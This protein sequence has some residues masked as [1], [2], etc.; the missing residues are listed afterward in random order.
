MSHERGIKNRKGNLLIESIVALSI[1]TIGIVGILGLLSQSVGLNKEVSQK[2]VAT[3]LAAEGIEVVKSLI[4]K[5]VADANPWNE[6]IA[7]GDYELSFDGTALVPFSGTPL[8]FD[9]DTGVY[10]YGDG[11]A[12]PFK[13]KVSI[14]EIDL[15]EGGT[16]ELKVVSSVTWTGRSGEESVVLEDHFFDWR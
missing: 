16:D 10:G 15:D 13:R 1:A 3:Y 2:F 7:G 9:S 14:T 8:K 6:G 4:D 12:T 5:N 11:V